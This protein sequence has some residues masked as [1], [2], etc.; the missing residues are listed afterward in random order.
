MRSVLAMLNLTL[1]AVME[2]GIIAALAYWGYKTADS[3]IT[4][5]PLV[6]IPP[7][8][9][10]GFWALVDFRRAGSLAEVLRLIQELAIAGMAAWAL[11]NAGTPI[12]GLSL[13]LISIVHHALVYVLGGTLL[14]A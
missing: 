5:F 12:L 9:G 13:A 7:L 10:F 1:R 11:L 6:I 2:L 4:T 14:K 8:I 3:R